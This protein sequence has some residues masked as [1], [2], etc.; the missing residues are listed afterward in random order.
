MTVANGAKVSSTHEGIIDV[1][2]LPAGARNAHVL[3]AMKHS[4]LSIVQLCNAGCKVI[5]SKWGTGVEVWYNRKVVLKGRKS[6]TNGL[7]YVPITTNKEVNLN[8]T[9]KHAGSNYKQ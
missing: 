5:F 9:L 8:K 3:P 1:P 6:M 2:G 7:W 4:L